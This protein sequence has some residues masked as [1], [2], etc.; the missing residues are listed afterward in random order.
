MQ[1][2]IQ[3]QTDANIK[4]YSIMSSE[5]YNTGGYNNFFKSP[6]F[7]IAQNL[8]LALYVEAARQL[9]LVWVTTNQDK[10]NSLNTQF[11][12]ML[13]ILRNR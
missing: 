6:D 4:I 5:L 8:H 9:N 1:S 2:V 7:S 3:Q 12:A 10:I 13:S 11:L